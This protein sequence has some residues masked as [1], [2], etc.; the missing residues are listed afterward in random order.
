MENLTTNSTQVRAWYDGSALPTSSPLMQ[1]RF[2]CPEHLHPLHFSSNADEIHQFAMS[3]ILPPIWHLTNQPGLV[4]EMPCDRIFQRENTFNEE[5]HSKASKGG[6]REEEEEFAKTE[7]DILERSIIYSGAFDNH[8]DGHHSMSVLPEDVTMLLRNH[9]DDTVHYGYELHHEFAPPSP[10]QMTETSLSSSC[11]D[12]FT[13]D[14]DDFLRLDDEFSCY[15]LSDH[16]IDDDIFVENDDVP[17]LNFSASTKRNK[18]SRSREFAPRQ[19][20]N[21]RQRR[22]ANQ[23]ERRRMQV[24]NDGFEKLRQHLPSIPYEKKLSKVD[25]LRAAIDYIGFMASL[26]RTE[27]E[28]DN[29]TPKQ[30]VVIYCKNDG[31][32]SELSQDNDIVVG[33][34]LS[35]SWEDDY[36]IPPENLEEKYRSS[37]D[38]SGLRSTRK[39]P[40]KTKIVR[41]PIWKPMFPVNNVQKR[42]ALIQGLAE[43]LSKHVVPVSNET[44]FVDPGRTR[45]ERSVSC[46]EYFPHVSYCPNTCDITMTTQSLS[47]AQDSVAGCEASLPPVSSFINSAHAQQAFASGD[48]YL[49]PDVTSDPCQDD[50]VFSEEGNYSYRV[51][52]QEQCWGSEE[53]VH[54][55]SVHRS[56]SLY[57]K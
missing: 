30:K 47:D 11:Q 41:A 4:D 53:A 17:D 7:K 56:L 33:H 2:H 5:A 25:T 51:N 10:Q 9:Y 8:S 52:Q 27:S 45:C 55:H 42:S 20:H 44:D 6:A 34:S 15:N 31:T 18:S 1:G 48:S 3:S 13:I 40:R 19:V 54:A 43:S 49:C 16:V 22:A 37:S 23:R 39:R 38:H 50:E 21:H 29:Q 12:E 35:W 57:V 32:D 36:D 24:I 46:N 14:C 28:N 26:L